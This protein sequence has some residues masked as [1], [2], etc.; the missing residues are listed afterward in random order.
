MLQSRLE[1]NGADRSSAA[2]VE[3]VDRASSDSGG[4]HD[5]RDLPGEIVHVSVAFCSDQDLM[6]IAHD[7]VPISSIDVASYKP[8]IIHAAVRQNE[9]TKTVGCSLFAGQPTDLFLR[10]RTMCRQRA[11]NE[12][13]HG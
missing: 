8:P 10:V 1:L 3:N 11:A 4:S 9:S 2:D 7:L 12:Y 5:R 13:L 6:L